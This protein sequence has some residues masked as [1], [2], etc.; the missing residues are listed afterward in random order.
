MLP[1]NFNQMLWKRARLDLPDFLSVLR[2]RAVAREFARARYIQDRFASPFFWFGILLSKLLICFQI[3][4]K[5]G[6]MPIIVAVRE[7]HIAQRFEYPGL[8][9][10]EMSGKDQI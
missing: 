8:M 6:Q 2:Y 5:I 1:E 7:K 10:V 9:L 3:G 4:A